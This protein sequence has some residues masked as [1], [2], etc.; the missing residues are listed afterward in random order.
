MKWSKEPAFINRKEE[1]SFLKFWRIL[2]CR[3]NPEN[4]KKAL[5]G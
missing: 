1:M 4:I 3:Q 2:D 5:K